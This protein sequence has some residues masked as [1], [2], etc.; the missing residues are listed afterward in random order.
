[1]ASAHTAPPKPAHVA[2]A[3]HRDAGDFKT[4]TRA[5]RRVLHALAWFEG[6]QDGERGAWPSLPELASRAGC[7][8][9]TVILALKR[10]SALMILRRVRSGGGRGWRNVW[11]F[12]TAGVPGLNRQLVRQ[13][14]RD[15]QARPFGPPRKRSR[16][17]KETVKNQ[18]SPSTQRGRTPADDRSIGPTVDGIAKAWALIVAQRSETRPPNTPKPARRA[19]AKEF[20]GLEDARMAAPRSVRDILGVPA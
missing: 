19:A 4:L 14:M 5:H 7:T 18:P 9:P 20:P 8:I 17:R 10:A 11:Q 16:F 12:V 13:W 15:L 2:Y 6:V 1:M 3:Y